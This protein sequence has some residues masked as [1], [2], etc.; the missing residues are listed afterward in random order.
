MVVKE[1]N[2]KRH[3]MLMKCKM[4]N[5]IMDVSAVFRLMIAQERPILSRY[6][7]DF[8]AYSNQNLIIDLII[9]YLLFFSFVE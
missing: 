8:L 6:I 7:F 9:V 1:E 4:E 2:V 3:A 5:A